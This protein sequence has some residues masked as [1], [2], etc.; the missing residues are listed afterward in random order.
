MGQRPCRPQDRPM[1]KEILGR[2]VADFLVVVDKRD[3]IEGEVEKRVGPL[4]GR[5][6]G[7]PRL[8]TKAGGPGKTMVCH[9]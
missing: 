7:F 9:S 3:A 8:P 1:G 4:A 6:E 2:G 5:T